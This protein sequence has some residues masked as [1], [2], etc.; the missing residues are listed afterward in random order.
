MDVC[1]MTN[2]E[3]FFIECVKKGINNEKLENKELI[4]KDVDYKQ[5][6]KLCASHSMSVIVC[7]AIENVRQEMPEGFLNA[8][9]RSVQRHV[10][11]DVQSEIDIKTVLDAFEDNGIKHM[12]LKGYHLKKLYPSTEMRYASDCDVLID[13]E[14]LKQVRALVDELGLATKRHDE[15]HDIVYY[16][17]TKTIFELHKC[18]FVGPLKKYFGIGFERATVKDGYKYFY[19]MNREIFYISILAHSAYHF[20]ESAGVGIRHLTDIY[21]YRKAYDLN[22]E[23]LDEELK[24]CGLLQFKNQFEKLSNFFFKDEQADEFTL[25]LADHIIESTLFSNEEKKA[26]SDV[27]S[28]SNDSSCDVKKAKKRTFWSALFPPKEN[29]QFSYP[30][31]KK[32]LWLLPI[33]YFVRWFHV[34]FTRPKNIS[35]LK[36]VGKV[37]SEELDEM[38]YIRTGLGIN[39]L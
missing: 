2:T 35:K 12:P 18:I 19:E 32:H 20:A 1:N 26:A 24:K 16:P 30:I 28:K 38:K 4:P 9:D 10:I 22:E 23:Y 15:H 5:L 7:K 34:L 27:A 37:K 8:I 17:E 21:L 14:Q 36:S 3:R 13:I 11:K 29:M 33:F 6:Y 39:E 25:K 31:L